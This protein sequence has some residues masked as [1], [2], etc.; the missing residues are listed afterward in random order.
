M[1]LSAARS[2][3]RHDE[4][5]DGAQRVGQEIQWHRGPPKL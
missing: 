2:E 5:E 1:R 3:E 4:R